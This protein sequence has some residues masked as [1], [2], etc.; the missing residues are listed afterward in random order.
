MVEFQTRLWLFTVDTCFISKHFILNSTI[1]AN[2][3]VCNECEQNG[4]PLCS[5]YVPLGNRGHSQMTS[6]SLI[7]TKSKLICEQVW[8]PTRAYCFILKM[9][10][11][12]FIPFIIS[13]KFCSIRNELT[14]QMGVH[15]LCKN[16]L[17]KKVQSQQQQNKKQTKIL[18]RDG[19]RTRYL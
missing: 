2:I 19:N 12:I 13:H 14:L 5:L 18:A 6:S 17:D 1:I 16:V 11:C 8:S 15:H 3:H 10:V 9:I 7:D 4:L